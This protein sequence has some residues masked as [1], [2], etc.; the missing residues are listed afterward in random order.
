MA[1]GQVWEPG[2]SEAHFL[3]TK[4]ML[5]STA[6]NTTQGPYMKVMTDAPLSLN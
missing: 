1:Q 2:P 3:I 5:V 6:H 4:K